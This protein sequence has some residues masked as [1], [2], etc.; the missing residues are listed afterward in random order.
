[1]D[2]ADDEVQILADGDHRESMN[3]EALRVLAFCDYFT[4]KPVGGA[5]IVAVHVYRYLISKGAEVLVV[6]ATPGTKTKLTSVQG[7]PTQTVAGRDLSRLFNA[8]VTLSRRVGSEARAAAGVFRPNVLHASSI[9]FRGSLAAARQARHY[10]TPL[11]TTG[12]VGS[13]SALAMVKRAATAS[14][15]NTV[16]RFILRSSS[17]VIAVSHNVARHLESLG[18]Q[19]DRITVVPNGVDHERFHPC[20]RAAHEQRVVFVGRLIGNKGPHLALEAFAKTARDFTTLTFAGDG[21]MRQKLETEARRLGVA[22][23]VTFLGQVDDVSEL[24]GTA[25]V[26]IRPSLTEGQSLALL[27]AMASGACVVASDIPANRELIEPEQAGLLSEP[28]SADDLARQLRR[29]IDDDAL[30]QRLAA[31]GRRRSLAHSWVACGR[32]TGKVLA[33]AARFPHQG[34]S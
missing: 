18:A 10:R 28:G 16:G 20:R 32:E 30:R 8:Q 33:E 15:E 34:R 11:V 23:S 9:H 21:P 7:V 31:E 19:R 6:S 29:V 5:E 4:E 2:S 1:M 22:P 27:E 3:L 17:R 14:Y 25:D 24:I 12:H 13:I 26:M